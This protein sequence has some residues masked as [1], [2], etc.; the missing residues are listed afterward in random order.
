M[1]RHRLMSGLG[2]GAQPRI[3]SDRDIDPAA[4]LPD[5][6]RV[7]RPAAV[8]V[9]VVDHGP[10]RSTVLLTRRSDFLPDHAGQISFPGG[11]IETTDEDE[12][13][14]AL[15][16]TEEEIG[17]ARRH[18]EILGRLDSYV[19]VTG[20]LIAPVVGI[21]SPPFELRP[22]RREVAAVFEIPLDVI[23]D[24]ANHALHAR[25]YQGR[26]R[27]FH[28]MTYGDHFIWGATAHMLVNLAHCLGETDQGKA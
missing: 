10:G 13:A 6:G 23:L 25:T 3:R 4:P 27:R 17:L 7:L 16:E 24:P 28:A 11:R 12:I 2:N 22:D 14:T 20:F 1:L 15:R 5:E 9:P 19:T 8:L 18:V 21:L 26:I